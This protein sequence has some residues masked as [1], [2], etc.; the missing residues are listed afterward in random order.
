MHQPPN[1]GD[2]ANEFLGSIRIGDELRRIGGREG[3][4]GPC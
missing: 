1:D 4:Y 3:V 2:L